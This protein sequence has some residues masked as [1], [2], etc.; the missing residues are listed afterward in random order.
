[1][2][3]LNAMGYLLVLKTVLET[4]KQIVDLVPKSLKTFVDSEFRH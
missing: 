3:V 4:G 2:S 1:M